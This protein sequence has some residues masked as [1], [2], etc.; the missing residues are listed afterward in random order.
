VSALATVHVVVPARNEERLI[1]RCLDALATS[2]ALLL[3]ERPTLAVR[4]TVVL[5][6][7]VD[8]TAAVVRRAPGV[9]AVH[10]TE[11]SAGGARAAGVARARDLEP[12]L[13]RGR[14]WVACTDADSVVPA[15]WL[16][17][18]VLAAEQGAVCRV[19]AVHP[20]LGPAERLLHLGWLARHSH[21][22]GHP[23]VY[24]ANLGFSLAA[25]EHVGGFAPL[26]CGEDVDLVQR[27][28]A[29]GLAVVSTGDDPVRTSARRSSRVRGGFA[30]Y[31]TALAVDLARAT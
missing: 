14:T 19:G 7:C 15:E 9:D 30:D 25:Y 6:G 26:A 20:E 28:R 24:G 13:D 16:V 4:V 18:Q 23:H 5:D 8:G 12:D 31:L 29:A 10:V 21:A 27:I 17:G 1:G 3:A 11:L 22:E 2:R